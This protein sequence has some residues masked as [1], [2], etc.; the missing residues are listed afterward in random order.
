MYHFVQLNKSI[1][2]VLADDQSIVPM[3]LKQAAPGQR[4]T[5]MCICALQVPRRFAVHDTGPSSADA[6]E[7]EY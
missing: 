6:H 4:E 7:D 5:E 1:T 3:P 2:M